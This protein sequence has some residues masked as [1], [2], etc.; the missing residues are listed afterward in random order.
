[1]MV[2]VLSGGNRL[3]EGRIMAMTLGDVMPVVLFFFCLK[4]GCSTIFEYLR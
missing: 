2:V 4:H 1:M 3:V